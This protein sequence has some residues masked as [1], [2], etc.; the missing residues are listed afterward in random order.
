MFGCFM[1][2]CVAISPSSPKRYLMSRG[3]NRF[4]RTIFAARSG[5]SMLSAQFF[6]QQ[7]HT[8]PKVPSPKG[9]WPTRVYFLS[10]SRD[11]SSSTCSSSNSCKNKLEQLSSRTSP[12]PVS[13]WRPA[14]LP[15]RPPRL[16]AT[17]SGVC[18]TSAPSTSVFVT[19]GADVSASLPP[20]FGRRECDIADEEVRFITLLNIVMEGTRSRMVGSNMS[21]PSARSPAGGC[22]RS[23]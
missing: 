21:A 4:F 19:S 11:S 17:S 20:R 9:P 14:Q 10:N 16:T 23:G 5:F 6:G 12:S 3:S 2:R 18:G 7:R 1:V 22:S 15:P 13:P 8:R